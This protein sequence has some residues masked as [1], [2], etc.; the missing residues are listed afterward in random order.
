M[1]AFSF[2]IEYLEENDDGTI[3]VDEL[4]DIMKYKSGRGDE[5]LYS[6]GQLKEELYKH[7][8][9]S[10]SITA[11]HQRPNVITLTTNVKRLI[12]DVHEKSTKSKDLSNIDG[13]ISIVGEY[14]RSEIK[15]MEGH[16]N[17]YPSTEEMK[18]LDSNL[19]YLPNSLRLLLQTII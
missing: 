5:Q 8:G 7:Y 11:I 10:V 13:M 16:R 2:A 3:T 9:N 19:Y 18:S 14:I 15:G 17:M 1:E 12:Q 4:F 6:T